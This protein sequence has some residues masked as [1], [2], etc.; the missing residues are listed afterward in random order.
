MASFTHVAQDISPQY[1]RVTKITIRVCVTDCTGTVY[2]TDMLLQGGSIASIGLASSMKLNTTVA[3]FILRG[4]SLLGVDSGY[5]REPYRS[6]VWQRLAGDLRPP[7]LAAMTRR[8]AFAEL[9]AMF[10]EF[11][12][13]RIKGRVVVEVGG[14]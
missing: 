3:P 14:A 7:H 4:V 10:D 13:G 9:P 12:G 6:G 8:V 11:I 5:I 2:I 1:G